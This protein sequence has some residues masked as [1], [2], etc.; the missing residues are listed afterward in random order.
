MSLVE[1][2]TENQK[3]ENH[4]NDEIIFGQP[5]SDDCF[6][7]IPIY[8]AKWHTKIFLIMAELSGYEV[9]V[10]IVI[11]SFNSLQMSVLPINFRLLFSSSVFS[12]IFFLPHLRLARIDTIDME[13]GEHMHTHTASTNIYKITPAHNFI[14]HIFR[15]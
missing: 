5:F 7:I 12:C 3:V 6:E 2:G 10:R 14:I 8:S 15:R 13:T 9:V 4:N 1:T 11:I